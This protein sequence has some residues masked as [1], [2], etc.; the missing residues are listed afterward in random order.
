MPNCPCGNPNCIFNGVLGSEHAPAPTATTYSNAPAAPT[1]QS[2]AAD[3]AEMARYIAATDF[4]F[5]PSVEPPRIDTMTVDTR[6]GPPIHVAL[7]RGLDRARVESAVRAAVE[8]VLVLS[9]PRPYGREIEA[10]LYQAI[11]ECL[12]RLQREAQ[13]ARSLGTLEYTWRTASDF[14]SFMP[15]FYGARNRDPNAPAGRSRQ[16][17]GP[18]MPRFNDF[19]PLSAELLSR[20]SPVPP[21]LDGFDGNSSPNVYS[22]IMVHDWALSDADRERMLHNVNGWWEGGRPDG[23]YSTL[24]VMW[25]AAHDSWLNNDCFRRTHIGEYRPVDTLQGVRFVRSCSTCERP[26]QDTAGTNATC[27][28]FECGACNRRYVDDDGNACGTCERCESCCSC[29][30]C[31][32][33]DTTVQSTCSNCDECSECCACHECSRCGDRFSEGDFCGECERC[34]NHCNCEASRD[35]DNS[36][37]IHGRGKHPVRGPGDMK[38]F[39]CK[40]MAGAEV[41]YNSCSDFDYIRDWARSWG[42]SV[43]EDGSCGWEAVTSPAAGDHMVRQARELVRAM[44]DAEC[45]VGSNCGLHVHVDASDL[46]WADIERL[47]AIWARV[48]PVMFLMG[49]Q[50]R[51]TSEWCAPMGKLFADAL[52]PRGVVTEGR[53]VVKATRGRLLRAIFGQYKGRLDDSFEAPQARKKMQDGVDKKDGARY[54]ALNLM[55]WLAG[56]VQKAEMRAGY[57]DGRYTYV[58]EGKDKHQRRPDCTV[59]FRLHRNLETLDSDRLVGWMKVLC[60]IVDFAAKASDAEVAALPKS[61]MRALAI[62]AP[63][64]KAWCLE[65]LKAWKR[66]VGRRGRRIVHQGGAYYLQANAPAYVRLPTSDGAWVRQYESTGANIAV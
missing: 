37:S 40:R 8:R 34:H 2:I 21:G 63:D 6:I 62:I 11:N 12:D 5:A 18:T 26:M 17:Q 42:A 59:E 53:G 45:N 43:H 35:D 20:Y 49:G 4:V 15:R 57:R 50:Q 30:V 54:A 56:R 7:P 52:R 13:E 27:E 64:C 39:R 14:E 28:C 19:R 38:V 47:C 36:D 25:T 55:P 10:A 41:E 48:E 9:Y 31:S 29:R 3:V 60:R 33:C 66:S 58:K 16:A 65:R 1:P 23:E 46:Q 51:V 32:S 24:A 22:W 44:K 61:A